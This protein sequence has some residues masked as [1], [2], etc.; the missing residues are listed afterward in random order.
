MLHGLS[1]L[2]LVGRSGI[3]PYMRAKVRR[4]S[5]DLERDAELDWLSNRLRD[6]TRELLGLMPNLPKETQG[7][8]DNVREAGSL[9]SSRR[10]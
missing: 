6:G 8:L 5:E 7:V 4:I 10:T 2:R 1:R 3:E 9:T